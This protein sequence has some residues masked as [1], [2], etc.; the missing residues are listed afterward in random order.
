MDIGFLIILSLC[1]VIVAILAGKKTVEKKAQ[2]IERTKI[3]ASTPHSTGR[4]NGTFYT[5][6]TFMLYYKN[7][8]HK[9]ATVRNGSIE[10]N[11]YMGKLEG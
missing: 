3:L 5:E 10:Y 7:G 6:T 4:L 2:E 8:T 9:A 11:S 1:V